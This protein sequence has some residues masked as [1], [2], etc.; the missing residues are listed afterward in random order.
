M[1]ITGI[2]KNQIK[3]HK[4]STRYGLGVHALSWAEIVLIHPLE[5]VVE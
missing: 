4:I 3:L 5:I 2:T 1:R